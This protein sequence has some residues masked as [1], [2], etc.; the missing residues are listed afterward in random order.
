MTTLPPS[1]SHPS[2]DRLSAPP[3]PIVLGGG[4]L[5]LSPPHL[6]LPPTPATPAPQLLSSVRLSI[7]SSVCPFEEGEGGIRTSK[8]PLPPPVL[9][10]PPLSWAEGGQG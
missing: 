6:P 3:I 1:S 10:L 2:S 9:H 7:P 5:V 4:A 8:Q